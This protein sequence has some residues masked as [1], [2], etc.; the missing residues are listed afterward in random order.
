MGDS[1]TFLASTSV[2]GTLF[3]INEYLLIIIIT[4]Q[5]ENVN[6]EKVAEKKQKNTR[7]SQTDYSLH[8]QLHRGGGEHNAY[9]ENCIFPKYK[10]H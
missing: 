2:L 4:I 8:L 7:T 1:A 10:R 3:L 5:M 9:A 6:M